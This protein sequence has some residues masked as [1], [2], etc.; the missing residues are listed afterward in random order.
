MVSKSWLLYNSPN[1]EA[2]TS[3]VPSAPT[4]LQFLGVL[5]VPYFL[6]ILEEFAFMSSL[7]VISL[8]SSPSKK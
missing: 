8:E 5:N 1:P 6:T 3:P 4:S 2:A 7:N